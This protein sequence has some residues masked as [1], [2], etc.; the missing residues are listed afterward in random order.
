MCDMQTETGQMRRDETR[1]LEMSKD[2]PQM[3]LP[4]TKNMDIRPEVIRKPTSF[5]VGEDLYSRREL[6]RP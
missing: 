6:H 3:Q 5:F 1:L 2:W 4:T